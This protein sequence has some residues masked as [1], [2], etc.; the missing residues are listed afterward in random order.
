MKIRNILVA[1]GSLFLPTS[2]LVRQFI[3]E[4]ESKPENFWLH[5][6]D[7]HDGKVMLSVIPS[8]WS[9]P[10]QAIV[11]VEPR[12]MFIPKISL[13]TRFG[14]EVFPT[15]WNENRKLRKVIREWLGAEEEMVPWTVFKVDD[16]ICMSREP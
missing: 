16:G 15:N 11:Q 14:H 12:S 3:E 13:R 4:I 9:G 1:I 10:G 8:N 5:S 6:R 7:A 2:P